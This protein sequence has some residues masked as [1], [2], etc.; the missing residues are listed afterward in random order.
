MS[1]DSVTGRFA[2]TVEGYDAKEFFEIAEWPRGGFGPAEKDVLR[3]V[4]GFDRDCLAPVR[5]LARL[6]ELA[7]EGGERG[8]HA[9]QII[10]QI[11]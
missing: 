7:L 1:A 3:M 2:F 6:R 5:G 11:V 4:V 10:R 8:F 9:N